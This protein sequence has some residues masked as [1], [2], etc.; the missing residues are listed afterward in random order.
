[1]GIHKSGA[2]LGKKV[3]RHSR[4]VANYCSLTRHSFPLRHLKAVHVIPD[5]KGAWFLFDVLFY[6]NTLFEPLVI[7]AAFGSHASTDI[8]GYKL[9]QNTVRASLIITLL[10][11]PGYFVTVL[12]I[13][14][15]T[16]VCGSMRSFTSRFGSA[17]CIPCEQTPGACVSRKLCQPSCT[18]LHNSLT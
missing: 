8:S 13:G 15:R 6:G 5:I 4:S 14:R 10:A 7:E 2:G 1:M 16:C 9:L 3:C 12:I 18:L 11:L 17:L